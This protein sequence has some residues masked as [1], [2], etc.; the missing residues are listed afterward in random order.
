MDSPSAGSFYVLNLLVAHLHNI[1]DKVLCAPLVQILGECSTFDEFVWYTEASAAGV[2][3]AVA[4]D[5]FIH[6]VE[7][8]GGT[9]SSGEP[10]ESHW[11]TAL[12]FAVR[13][14]C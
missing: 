13:G 11:I 9:A 8:G 1:H 4:L 3:V 6:D 7:V 5:G 10:E 2:E 14:T 12:A